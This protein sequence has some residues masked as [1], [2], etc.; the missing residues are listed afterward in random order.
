MHLNSYFPNLQHNYC[1]FLLLTGGH[2]FEKELSLSYTPHE[3]DSGIF[4]LQVLELKTSL[5]EAVEEL[6]I[7]MERG[8]INIL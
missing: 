8:F 3:T 6:H 7:H 1:R 2:D 5:L 4:S